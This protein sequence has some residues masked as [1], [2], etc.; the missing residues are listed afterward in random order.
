[1]KKI[2]NTSFLFRY[3]LSIVFIFN[4]AAGLAA[5]LENINIKNIND[6]PYIKIKE[7]MLEASWVCYGIK[8]TDTFSLSRL[9]YKFDRCGMT[10][11]I[12]AVENTGDNTTYQGDFKVAAISDVHGQ[13]D[14][15]KRLFV[16]NKIVD[17][18]GLWTFGNNH[19]VI[20]GDIFDRGEQVT[21]ILWYLYHLEG[22]AEKSGGKLHLL[23]GNHEVMVLNQDLRYLHEKYIKVSKLFKQPFETL[24]GND[25]ILGS[26]LRSKSV[27]VKINNV[28]YMH[29]GFSP[30]ITSI[31]MN[32]EE[33]NTMFK[34]SLVKKELN[35]ERMIEEN[36]L[37][38]T[39]GPIWYRGYFDESAISEA[40]VD[41]LLKHF[42]VS[43]IVVGH[44]SQMQIERHYNGKV[45]AID[46][47][48]K[49]GLY[50]E[51]L[52]IDDNDLYR[53]KPN[54][55]RSLLK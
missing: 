40:Q 7:S 8:K 15:M 5:N 4:C 16:E 34:Q 24:Y 36:Y 14:L 44:T 38:G 48:I 37:H 29:G 43:H 46:T 31:S 55:E 50:G 10:A 2:T 32:L 54:G 27:L 17:S 33:I 21:E 3:C 9:P 6:G 41:V 47:S 12:E 30:N 19:L 35:R 1:M 22:S 26:W 13:F 49:N 45:I 52:I 53:A 18:S 42:E 20:T 39:D 11:T 25:S 28:L 23:L 51:L